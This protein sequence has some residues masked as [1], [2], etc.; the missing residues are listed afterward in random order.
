MIGAHI[1][2]HVLWTQ[3]GGRG[4]RKMIIFAQ[5]SSHI[6]LF[7]HVPHAFQSSGL[8]NLHYELQ[9]IVMPPTSFS[10]ILTI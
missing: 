8:S 10:F 4:R 3:F 6:C 1:H 2:D 7:S 9:S 5:R